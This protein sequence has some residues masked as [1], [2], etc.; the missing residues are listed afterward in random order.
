MARRPNAWWAVWFAVLAIG[1]GV[2]VTQLHDAAELGPGEPLTLGEAPVEQLGD[3]QPLPSNDENANDD[4]ATKGSTQAVKKAQASAAAT[5]AQKMLLKPPGCR[6]TTEKQLREFDSQ[7]TKCALTLPAPSAFT[8]PPTQTPIEVSLSDVRLTSLSDETQQFTMEF[9]RKFK[10][11]D[12]KAESIDIGSLWNPRMMFSF[13]NSLRVEQLAPVELHQLDQ[14]IMLTEHLR[15]TFQL[16]TDYKKYPFDNIT[17]SAQMWSTYGTDLLE[18]ITLKYVPAQ[19]ASTSG[20]NFDSRLVATVGKHGLPLGPKGEWGNSQMIELQVSA[21]R[22][23]TVFGNEVFL[24]ITTCA[25]VVFSSLFVKIDNVLP[26]ILLS[27]IALLALFVYLPSIGP[28][29]HSSFS[30]AEFWLIVQAVMAGLACC[31]HAICLFI[32]DKYGETK[33]VHLDI[34][35]RAAYLLMYAL[36][37]AWAFAYTTESWSTMTYVGVVFSFILVVMVFVL[38]FGV[39]QKRSAARHEKTHYPGI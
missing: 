13:P 3:A 24:P 18:P 35:M 27:I 30:W 15:V 36:S 9:T 31:H 14:T 11:K 39:L 25:V 8:S 12:A 33:T 6:P 28:P 10:W 26:R 34:S 20:F 5:A 7:R 1:S 32:N 4:P 38:T 23:K 22:S 21:T 2:E 16:S 19:L 17:L 29:N 37:Y